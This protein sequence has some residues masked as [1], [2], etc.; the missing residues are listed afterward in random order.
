MLSARLTLLLVL[1]N[2]GEGVVDLV[3]VDGGAD[4][5]SSSSFEDY[6][7]PASDDDDEPVSDEDDI[8]SSPGTDWVVTPLV[9]DKY[10]P[11]A[12]LKGS[13][14]RDPHRK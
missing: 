14:T 5:E 7:E 10:D 2:G 12:I 1:D 6:D 8:V 9:V 3:L 4:D 13:E 11:P